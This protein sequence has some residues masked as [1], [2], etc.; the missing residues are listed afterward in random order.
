MSKKKQVRLTEHIVATVE[1][2]EPASYAVPGEVAIALNTGRSQFINNLVSKVRKGHVVDPVQVIGMLELIRDWTDARYA[3]DRRNTV[4]RESLTAAKSNMIELRTQ[5][6][7]LVKQ[8]SDSVDFATRVAHR[9]GSGPLGLEDD[10][11]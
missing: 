8:I 5:V 4:V 6:S 11:E 7:E 1:S 9:H 2:G 3:D 10:P